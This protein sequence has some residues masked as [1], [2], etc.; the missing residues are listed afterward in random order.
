MGS[1]RGMNSGRESSSLQDK[2]THLLGVEHLGLFD[3]F[4]DG[5]RDRRHGEDHGGELLIKSEGKLVN[6]GNIVGDTCFGGEVLEI[7]DVFLESIVHNAIR[8]FE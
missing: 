2:N 5:G 1:S 7:S 4:C 3:L 8:V 6:E